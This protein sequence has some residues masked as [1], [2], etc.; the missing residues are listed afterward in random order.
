MAIPTPDALDALPEHRLVA[1]DDV[2]DDRRKERTIMRS[3]RDKW[4][5][6]IEPVRIL[7]GP[8]FDRF[9]KGLIVLPILEDGFFELGELGFS[10]GERK[11]HR[12]FSNNS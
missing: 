1:R 6:I 4:R 5:T 9:L 2:L 10:F 11:G 12:L 7:S 3:T 8:R